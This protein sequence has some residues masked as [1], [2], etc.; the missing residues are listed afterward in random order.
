MNQFN[1]DQPNMG[2]DNYNNP[3]FNNFQI[4]LPNATTVLVLGIISIVGCFCYGIVGIICGIIALILAKKDKNAY[5][6]N[7]ERYTLS[8]LKNLNSGRICAYIGLSI[9]IIYLLISISIIA[10]FGLEIFTNPEAVIEK[11]SLENY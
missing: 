7:P 9:S 3:S 8:S 2:T 1:S 10:F 11:Y 4:N 5:N 6:I